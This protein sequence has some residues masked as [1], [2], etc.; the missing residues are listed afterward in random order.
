MSKNGNH[1]AKA[2]RTN[3]P[4]LGDRSGADTSPTRRDFC[5]MGVLL[6][7]GTVLACRS[8][9]SVTVSE[10]AQ[11]ETAAQTFAQLAEREPKLPGVLSVFQLRDD[12]SHIT[13]TPEDAEL[14]TG[15]LY[16]EAERV[17]RTGVAPRTAASQRPTAVRSQQ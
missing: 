1:S 13:V 5:L 6:P 17:L 3:A 8:T 10:D 2:G 9:S 7:L 12:F 14:L 11:I 15:A 4:I 16:L